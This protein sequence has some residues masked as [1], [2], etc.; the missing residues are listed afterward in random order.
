MKK[1]KL[2]NILLQV[3]KLFKSPK[4]DKNSINIWTITHFLL[5][6]VIGLFY[7][8]NYLQ[9]FIASIIFEIYEIYYFGIHHETYLN[10]IMDVIFNMTGYYIGSYLLITRSNSVIIITIWLVSLILSY[11][12]YLGIDKSFYGII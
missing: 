6:V 8:H 3:G 12:N 7:K 4:N 1:R 9:L 2:D 11:K 5:F 10:R